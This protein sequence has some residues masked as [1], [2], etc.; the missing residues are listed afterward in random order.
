M[1]RLFAQRF[2]VTV[3]HTSD[4]TWAEKKSFEDGYNE[5]I[6]DYIDE[7]FGAGSFRA[8]ID[9]VDRYRRETYRK[10]LESKETGPK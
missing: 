9:D 4:I 1:T 3:E 7:K 2:S 10:Y 8:A 5:V 6:R